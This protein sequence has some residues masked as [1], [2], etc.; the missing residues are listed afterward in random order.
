MVN[1]GDGGVAPPADTTP[2]SITVS[3]GTEV[4]IAGNL[5]L[6]AAAKNAAG[7]D[8][9]ATITWSSG[10]D[11]IA[12][13]D[14][15]G[16]VTGVARGTVTIQASTQGASGTVSGTRDVLVRIASISLSPSSA[17]LTSINDTVQFTAEAKDATGA[18]V[19]G[20]TIGFVIANPA[21]LQSAGTGAVVAV[22]NG[23]AG[24]TAE[25]DGRT[26][27]ATVTVAQVATA[28]SLPPSVDTLA[29]LG[30]MQ[31]YMAS[32]TDARGNAVVDGFTWT[33]VDPSVAM[34]NG[35]SNMISATAV[36]N[37]TTAIQVERDGLSASATLV[38][39]QEV[40]SVS[41]TPASVSLLETFAEQLAGAAV[42][43]RGN[44]VAG[45]MVTWGSNDLAVATVDGSG[46]VTGE[47]PGMAIVTATAGTMSGTANVT[48]TTPSLATH[49][50]PILT[51]NCAVSGCHT[52][53]APAQGMNLSAGQTFTNTVNVASNESPLLR[54]DPFDPDLSYLVH[55]IQGTQATVGGSGSQ[56]PLGG[57]AL[58]QA[59]ID[60]VRAWVALGALNN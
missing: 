25:A 44:P 46:L 28:L 27:Q 60:T 23:T 16:R 11:A 51:T 34:V 30:D 53:G 43:A 7:Q 21:V 24:V 31:T 6:S 55:K 22:A 47:G 18:T 1:C 41:V 37:G 19:P 17:T 36:A 35:T 50:Q 29:S 54:I 20:V 52:G 13:V 32:A 45:V 26:A 39:K 49:V 3:G 42:D 4:D 40:A 15:T 56:M 38:V 57:A 12:T 48:V 2:A 8:V 14:N 5:Q 33:A 9:N 58:S 59:Q 10:D